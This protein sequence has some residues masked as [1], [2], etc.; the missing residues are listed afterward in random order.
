MEFRP[1]TTCR[2]VAIT[3]VSVIRKPVPHPSGLLSRTTAG[4]FHLKRSRTHD[5][6]VDFDG[7][8]RRRTRDR[9]SGGVCPPSG[10]RWQYQQRKQCK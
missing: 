10:K 6:A 7:R 1:S 9:Q 8:A 2:F 3:P 4:N 5:H